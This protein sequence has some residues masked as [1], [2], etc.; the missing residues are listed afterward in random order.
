MAVARRS[1]PQRAFDFP[2]PQPQRPWP[3]RRKTNILDIVAAQAAK[4]Q[5]QQR[6]AEH[7]EEWCVD[8]LL[9]LALWLRE[10]ASYGCKFFAI[11]DFRS[12][13]RCLPP[14]SKAWGALPLRAVA[15]GL[16]RGCFHADGS[17]QYVTARAKR[18]HAHPVRLWEIA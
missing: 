1:A 15:A 18:T 8:V 5:G 10:Q 11:E 7:A 3:R 6:A 4:L 16:I 2:D 9:E 12:E 14:S 17:P 13:A